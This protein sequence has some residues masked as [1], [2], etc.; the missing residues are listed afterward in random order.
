MTLKKLEALKVVAQHAQE[1]ELSAVISVWRA[2]AGLHARN[3]DDNSLPASPPPRQSAIA[4]VGSSDVAGPASGLLRQAAAGRRTLRLLEALKV[5]VERW[6]QPESADRMLVETFQ[7]WRQHP[8]SS[9]GRRRAG[10]IS[11]ISSVEPSPAGS[12]TAA[13]EWVRP[14]EALGSTRR[15]REHH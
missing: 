15:R 13:E 2:A 5:V 6:D 9:L 14:A 10:S 11:S 4:A 7:A 3:E 1:S 12:P 8:A